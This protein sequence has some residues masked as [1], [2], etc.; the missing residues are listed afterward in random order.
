MRTVRTGGL[1]LLELLIA[2]GV[3]GALLA[4]L[5]AMFFMAGK[6]LR[7]T[8]QQSDLLRNIQVITKQFTKEAERSSFTS[9]AL[10]PNRAVSFVSAIDSGGAFVTDPRGDPVWQQYVVFYWNSGTGDVKRVNVPIPAGS[11][12]SQISLPISSLG[13]GALPVYLSGG[14]VLGREIIGFEPSTVAPRRVR[15]KVTAQQKGKV[16]RIDTTLELT[17]RA[18]PRN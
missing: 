2:A 17:A 8:D 1:A 12:P 10:V 16:E 4:V 11:T 9:I 5:F 18:Y 7:R 13:G 3:F 14:R 6:A 15:L